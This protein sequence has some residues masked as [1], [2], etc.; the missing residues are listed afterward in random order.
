MVVAI[1]VAT[2]VIVVVVIVVVV[3][4][5]KGFIA[6]LQKSILTFKVWKIDS[7]F[8]WQHFWLTSRTLFLLRAEENFNFKGQSPSENDKIIENL[9]DNAEQLYL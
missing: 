3:G 9:F 8:L 7:G 1:V 2:A 6:S 5:L 4:L